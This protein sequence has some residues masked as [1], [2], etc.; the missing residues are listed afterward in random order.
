MLIRKATPNDSEILADCIFLAMGDIT[1]RFIGEENTEKAIA[2]LRSMTRERANQYSYENSWV[3]EDE[4]KKVVAAAVLYD[5]A[6]LNELRKPVMSMLK[7]VYNRELHLED[8]T[9]KGEYYIDCIG[10]KPDQQGKGI[11]S[12]ILRFLIDEYVIQKGETLGLLVDKENPN[13]KKLYL[14][15][16]FQSAGTK[17]LTGKEMEHLQISPTY[18]R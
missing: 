18:F 15:L 10:V 1:Y 17:V 7:Q 5:G 8:E 2:F 12:M 4:N 3:V 6:R 13:A 11:G 16:G 14:K 9:E